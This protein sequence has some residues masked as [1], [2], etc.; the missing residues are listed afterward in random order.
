MYVEGFFV[1]A[2]TN[3]PVP[4]V[5]VLVVDRFGKPTGNGVAADSGGYFAID[6]ALLTDNSYYL[7]YATAIDYT[8]QLLDPLVFSDSPIVTMSRAYQDLPAVVVTPP[9]VEAKKTTA[10]IGWLLAAAA[11]ALLLFGPKHSK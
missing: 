5:S 8:P 3:R 1:D 6:N 9:H 4:G 7:L 11:A 2:L 10:G